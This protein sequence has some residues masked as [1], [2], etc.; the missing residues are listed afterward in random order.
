MPRETFTCPRCFFTAPLRADMRFCPHCGLPEPSDASGDSAPIDLT[1]GAA[2]YRVGARAAIGSICNLYHCTFH[3][4][5]RSIEGIF[6]IAREPQSNPMV[7]NEASV[8]RRLHSADPGGRYGPFLPRVQESLAYSDATSTVSRQANILRLHESIRRP[9]VELYTLAEV[10]AA[11]PDGLDARDMAW[12]WRRLLSVLGFLRTS[13]V[14]HCA[15]LPMHVLIEPKD[16][17]LVLIDFCDAV[18]DFRRNP[19]PP[20]MING[21]YAPWYREEMALRSAPLPALDIAFGARCMIDL[22]GGDAVRA[23]MPEAVDPSIQRHLA[24]CIGDASR[25][26]LDAWKLLE[27]FDRLIEVLWGKRKFRPLELPGKA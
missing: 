22:L 21:G 18:H 10:R 2:S 25:E 11:Y 24:R 15:V 4:G 6:K 27:D 20:A 23:T 19:R 13:D 1:V 17:K 5:L 3:D 9:F 12:I 14:V 7:S 8:L 16:H 26:N